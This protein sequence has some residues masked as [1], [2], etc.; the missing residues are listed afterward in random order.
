MSDKNQNIDKL[1]EESL[2]NL[3]VE[4][5][6]GSWS[7]VTEGLDGL[8]QVSKGKYFR[9]VGLSVAAVAIIVY[10]FFFRSCNVGASSGSYIL[11]DRLFILNKSSKIKRVAKKDRH[12][13][14]MIQSS[15][16]NISSQQRKQSFITDLSSTKENSHSEGVSIKADNDNSFN[17]EIELSEKPNLSIESE[18]YANTYSEKTIAKEDV[19][20]QNLSQDPSSSEKKPESNT[21]LNVD[22]SKNV[23]P[24]VT[25]PSPGPEIAT[26]LELEFGMGIMQ[27]LNNIPQNITYDNPLLE[28]KTS[29]QISSAEGFVQLKYK[30]SNFYGKTGFRIGEF[31]ENRTFVVSTEMHDTSGGYQSWNLSRYW[32]YDTIGYYDD[33]NTPGQVYPVLSPTYHIDTLSAQWNSRDVLYYDKSSAA[34]KNRYRYIEIPFIVGYQQNFNRLG[35]FIDAGLGM[36]FMVNTTGAFVENGLIQS[37]DNSTNPYKRVNFNYMLNLGSNYS[38]NNQWNLF[39]QASYKSNL[40]S[41]YKPQFEKGIKYQSF[42]VQFG[43]SYIL[44]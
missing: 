5:S 30:I 10:I 44:K 17:S 38:L 14:E 35:I 13:L 29:R 24:T 34:Y 12:S 37:I 4:P 1:F 3:T 33:P 19:K 11:K 28:S 7:K 2:G 31:G 20:D 21:L 32:T 25:S 40:T 6:D 22:E 43:M 26:G 9:W 41:I 16:E 42:G 8:S 36:G 27:V 18:K 39:I 15:S 23:L